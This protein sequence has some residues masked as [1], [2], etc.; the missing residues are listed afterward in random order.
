MIVTAADGVAIDVHLSRGPATPA[1]APVVIVCHGFIQNRWAFEVPE[2]SMLDHLRSL[3][4]CVAVVELRGRHAGSRTAAGLHEYTDVD[5]PAVIA[6][7]AARHRSVT[8][9]GHS[10]GGL[11]ATLLPP[12]AREQLDAVITIGAPLFAGR[13]GLHPFRGRSTSMVMRA[14]RAAHGQGLAF[15]GR[16]WSGGL[17][18][19]RALLDVPWL[20]APVRLWAP[21]S[22]ATEELAFTL[23]QSFANDSC[24]V[25]ADLLELVVTDGARA[26]RL[27][28]GARLASFTRPILVIAGDVDD[29]APPVG[30]RP[31]F[32]RVGSADKEY[33]EVGAASGARVGHIDLLI[34]TAAPALVW[35]P[36]AAFLRRQLSLPGAA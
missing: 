7:L 15:P 33:L 12:A 23:R 26:G 22:L 16:R 34:G 30:A 13:P 8:W 19:V 6:A 21:G 35:A 36:I 25:F 29:L 11:I 27:D 28:A 24:A 14:A 31:L 17:L 10:M 5:A 3:G 2:R 20:P 9:L 32:E 4:V 1:D 18:A